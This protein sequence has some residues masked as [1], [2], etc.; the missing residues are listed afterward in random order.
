MTHGLGNG[1]GGTWRRLSAAAKLVPIAAFSVV[2]AISGGSPAQAQPNR[3]LAD[4][5]ANIPA[6]SSMRL[7][8]ST[9]SA[10]SCERAAV[11]A[12]DAARATEGVVPLVL[13]ADFAAL[14]PVGQLLVIA[15]LERT[16]RGL[17][18][19]AGLSAQLDKLAHAGAVADTDPVGPSDTTWGSNWAGGENAVLEADYDWMYNDGPKSFNV[20]CPA[21]GGGGCW[22]HRQNILGDWG[23][24]P[25]MGAA[26]AT[27]Q[28]SG[29]QYLSMTQLFAA[30]LAGP[31]A[32]RL[33]AL[34]S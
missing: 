3:A 34:S 10:S 29:G 19:F 23:P 32:Y 12:I 30:T 31:I 11:R 26:I 21:G 27:V 33:P 17:P 22:G 5:P 4:P 16:D 6:P 24:S 2:A 9:G 28:A 8:C 1:S 13:P 25:S 7:A 20:D 18:G 14:Q 15:D